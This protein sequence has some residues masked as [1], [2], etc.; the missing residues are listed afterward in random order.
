[1]IDDDG[2]ASRLNMGF[3]GD[4]RR[5]H[6]AIGNCPSEIDVALDNDEHVLVA[7]FPVW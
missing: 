6:S 2:D 5:A 7:I 1:M 3:S 4:Y